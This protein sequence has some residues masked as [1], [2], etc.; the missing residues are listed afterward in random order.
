MTIPRNE[1]PRPDF[2]RKNWIN[3][4]GQWDFTFDDADR[5]LAEE[6]FRSDPSVAFP[7][8][9]TVPFCF[10]SKNSGIEDR[11]NHEIL[12]YRR[13][14]DVGPCF[15][16]K[17]TILHFGAVDYETD[18]WLN[19]NHV[20]SHRGGSVSFEMEISAFIKPSE[21]VLVLRILDRND[22][23]QP[24]GKQYWRNGV[25][26]CWY[27]RTSGIWQT[28]WLEAVGSIGIQNF[29]ISPDIDS[30]RVSI[31]VEL[32]RDPGGSVFEAVVSFCDKNVVII[33][34]TVPARI[35]SL[36]IDLKQMD[37][38]D[39][40]HL[41]TP[42]NPQLYQ[43]S[44][45]LSVNGKVEDEVNS[46]FGMRK[47]S[48]RNGAILLNNR[49]LYQRL[50]LDQG[51]WPD[52]LLTPPS[53]EAI[54]RDIELAKRFGFN[55]AR[56]HQKVEDPRYYYWA[57]RLGFLV[58]GEMPSAYEFSAL[59]AENLTKEFIEFIKRDRNH[60]SII[61]WVP[62]NESWGVRNIVADSRQQALSNLMVEIV[63]TFDGTRPVSANDGWEQTNTDLCCI[64]CYAVDGS[65]LTKA[66][67]DKDR[68]V[69]TVADER[70]IY[71][72]GY[73]H[74]GEPILLTEFGGIAF[75]NDKRGT[76]GYN[77]P[78]GSEKEFLERFE[79]LFSAIRDAG[80]F[81]GYCYTQLYDVEQEVNGLVTAERKLKVSV[82]AIRRIVEGKDIEA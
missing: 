78:V 36:S 9:I 41:W 51:Y 1:Y 40:I 37:G 68:L 2:E 59:E 19:G 65:A 26:R 23:S 42:L 6:W 21:N 67:S 49:P 14:F 76:W 17:R 79:S 12:W 10:Q 8:S 82:D 64:H 15:D 11:S 4:N 62:L 80:Y 27:T 55:G 16:G 34:Q 39:D 28:V 7:L 57:D 47:I 61:T 58:W 56:K 30:S 46:Y 31:E 73:H 33:S 44:F 60:P 22:L 77:Y 63:R 69:G 52:S 13:T 75:K 72:E 18:V 29:S 66:I 48:I 45:S 38:V 3:L 53:D 50:V 25:D 24:R 81:N 74:E 35:F 71:A 54:V 32:D 5:G 43:I 20:G 70:M